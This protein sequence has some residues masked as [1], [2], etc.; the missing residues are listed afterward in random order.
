MSSSKL[1]WAC[2]PCAFFNTDEQLL[3]INNQNLDLNYTNL[4]EF[5]KRSENF[6]IVF[7]INST[8]CQT[9]QKSVSEGVLLRNINS[10]YPILHEYVLQLFIDFILHKRKFG[11]G[12]EREFYKNIT[13]LEFVDRLLQKRAV[14]F[15][16][17]SDD[18]FLLN[19]IRGKG[20]WET[21]G[22]DVEKGG[23]TL[24]NCLSYDEIKLAAF[25]SVSSY[26]YFINNGNRHNKGVQVKNRANLE[27]EGVIIGLIG[28]RLEKSN[29]ME[30]Q[31][32]IISK[33]QNVE[34]NGYGTLFAPTI[35]S[36]FSGFYGKPN[37]TYTNFIASGKAKNSAQYVKG[38]GNDYFDNITYSK[39]I[40]IS[41]DTLL[42]EANH[43]AKEIGTS[44]YVYVVGIGLGVWQYSNH[45]KKIFLDTFVNRIQ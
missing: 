22:K 32:I 5:I 1:N 38:F 30:Y 25:L 3:T 24:E 9:L 35:A 18:Y 36:L 16:N 27:E 7:P 10:S 17:P 39:R 4:S 26:S 13:L 14:M 40:T 21:V 43:R 23:L 42:F 2:D 6:P 29:V 20:N 15:M 41:I 12:I 8:R 28:A 19:K 44:G 31:E 11:S 37:W 33:D 34:A 45:Q